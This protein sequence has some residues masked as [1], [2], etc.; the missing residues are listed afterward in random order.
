MAEEPVIPKQTNSAFIGTD[1]ENRLRAGGHDSLVA[2]GVITNNSVE[3][4]VRMAGDLGFRIWFVADGCFT[5]ARTVWNGTPRSA[6]DIHAMS[7]A[8][9]D[10][11]YC[12]VT[13]VDAL[14]VASS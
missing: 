10:S 5:F 4:T 9:L 8:N 11:E 13:T 6:E 2:V 7:L 14:L 12:A 3:A 1:L